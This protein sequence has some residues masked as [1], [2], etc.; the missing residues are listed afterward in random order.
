MGISQ[1]CQTI[2]NYFQNVRSPFP[3]LRRTLLICSLIKRPGLS[4][5]NSVSN[6]TKD[7]NR[8]GIPT[9]SMPDGS[10]NLTVGF[11]YALVEEIYRALRKDASVQGGTV[12]GSL[13]TPTGPAINTGINISGIF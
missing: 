13:E 4:V 12:P 11:T 8:I 6:I 5:V 3:Q 10:V 2:K 9:G 1:I 7:L